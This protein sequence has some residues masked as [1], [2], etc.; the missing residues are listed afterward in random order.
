M[1]LVQSQPDATAGDA[2]LRSFYGDAANRTRLL[3]ALNLVP[4]SVIAFLWFIAVIRRRIGSREDRFFATVFLGSG[5]IFAAVLLVG[6]AALATPGVAMQGREDL[7]DLDAIRLFRS[8]GAA[9]LAVHAPRLASVFVLATST[10]GRRTKAFPR[11]LTAM[12]LVMAVLM[13]VNYTVS[14]VMPFLFPAWVALVSAA[15][16]VRGRH[17]S[18]VDRTGAADPSGAAPDA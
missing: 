1:V 4:L 10:L 6:A 14:E 12:G 2:A 5:L 8:M 9:I 7:L 17:W 11:W 13:I 18:T 16:L 3:I 15:I